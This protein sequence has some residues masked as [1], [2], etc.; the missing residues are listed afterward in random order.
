MYSE[1]YYRGWNAGYQKGEDVGFLKG[2]RFGFKSGL[3]IKTAL[4]KT[5]SW[6]KRLFKIF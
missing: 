2:H 4:I 6:W 3:E 1:E 5:L